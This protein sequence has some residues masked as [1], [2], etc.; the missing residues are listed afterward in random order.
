MVSWTGHPTFTGL[1]VIAPDWPHF[2]YHGMEDL[3]CPS[4]K[5]PIQ[6]THRVKLR[7]YTVIDIN[8]RCQASV[9]KMVPGRGYAWK[10]SC[11]L[12]DMRTE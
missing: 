4:C 12:K 6:S 3:E 11:Y 1:S 5:A 2:Y 9:T 10:R 8:Y 7:E